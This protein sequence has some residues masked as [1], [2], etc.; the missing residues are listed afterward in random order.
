MGDVS[1]FSLSVRALLA[2]YQWRR[3]DP[4][5][6]SPL[7]KPLREC[8]VALVTTAGLVAPTQEAFDGS[9]RGGDTSFRVIDDNVNLHTLR[10]TH[11]SETFDHEPM[12]ADPNLVF[13]RDRLRELAEEGV[14]ASVADRHLSFMGSITKTGPLIA[15]TAPAAAATL[16]AQGV[17]AVLL[18]PV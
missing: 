1:E 4:V 13:P 6:W 11:R 2:T 17:D 7:R 5:P 18:V 16:V 9:I 15:E 12:R 14:I 3:I 8:R 10:D